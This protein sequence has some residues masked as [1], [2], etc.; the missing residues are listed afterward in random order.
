MCVGP[1]IDVSTNRQVGIVSNGDS[2]CTFDSPS[3]LTRVTDNFDYIQNIIRRTTR[4]QHS[5]QPH[6]Q[7]NPQSNPQQPNPQNPSNN[8]QINL[9][10]NPQIKPPVMP[11]TN[12]MPGIISPMLQQP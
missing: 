8:P 1:L 7:I 5:P 6:P 9:P 3:I 12:P 4:P 10:N 2:D 11:Q